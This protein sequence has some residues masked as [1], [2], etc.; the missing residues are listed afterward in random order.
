MVIHHHNFV[1]LN[2]DVCASFGITLLRAYSGRLS[3]LNPWFSV[4]DISRWLTYYYPCHQSILFTSEWAKNH[5]YP[6]SSS[7]NA[8]SYIIKSALSQGPVSYLPQ[9]I[10]EFSMN[11][12]SSRPQSPRVF[13][14]RPLSYDSLKHFIKS[15][16][17]PPFLPNTLP[18][19]SF[20]KN[21]VVNLAIT[22]QFPSP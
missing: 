10:S 19:F 11:G 18:F 20:L 13:F 5:L 9:I 1:F 21:L 15:L 14:N 7:I 8:D 16:L 22:M 2:T 17:S 3:W 6:T 12:I 4:R